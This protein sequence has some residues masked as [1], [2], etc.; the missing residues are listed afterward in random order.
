MDSLIEKYGIKKVLFIIGGIFLTL[1]LILFFIKRINNGD[2]KL[3]ECSKSVALND[4]FNVN[5][6]IKFYKND[7]GYKLNLKFE[8]EILDD[9]STQSKFNLK[10]N[11]ESNLEDF[12]KNMFE[13]SYEYVNTNYSS[14]DTLITYNIDI[15][16]TQENQFQVYGDLGYDIYN[17]SEDELISRIEEEGFKCSK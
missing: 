4:S 14:N 11:L 7:S 1:F 2:K 13:N 6:I 10:N 5:N 12:A 8:Y 3:F 17:L 9:L 16:I 15:D